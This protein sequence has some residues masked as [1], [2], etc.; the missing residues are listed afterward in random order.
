MP[1]YTILAK[2]R[3]AAPPETNPLG[4]KNEIDSSAGETHNVA[5]TMMVGL[6]QTWPN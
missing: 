5:S 3:M 1:P 2:F 4:T 6:K